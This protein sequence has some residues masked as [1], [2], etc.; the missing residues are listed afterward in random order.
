MTPR[1]TVMDQLMTIKYG[2]IN[3]FFS[4]TA[5]DPGGCMLQASKYFN[6][7][8]KHGYIRPLAFDI[9]PRNRRKE[10]FYAPTLKGAKYVDRESEY[11]YKEIRATSTVRH[12][13]MKYDI[14]LSLVRLY[15]DW[16]FQFEYEKAFG[17]KKCDTFITARKE[18]ITLYYW[19]EIERK[20]ECYKGVKSK[21]NL[22]NKAKPKLPFGTKCLFVLSYLYHDPLLRPQ[23]YRLNP[24]IENR[25]ETNNK[26]FNRF[27]K[28]VPK[29][30]F[31]FLNFINFY[32]LNE[33][34]WW[35]GGRNPRKILQ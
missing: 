2:S 9:T 13:S 5:K 34:V 28:S 20:T 21:I 1:E 30:D 17:G 35:G 19:V 12:D 33:A 25:I 26:Q 16:N 15:P 32:R 24:I 14:A 6:D 22:F 8:I 29:G 18:D 23:E 3:N 10:I 31:L 11:K 27:V 7:F 4:I